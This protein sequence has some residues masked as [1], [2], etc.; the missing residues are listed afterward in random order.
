MYYGFDWQ[1][2]H[3]PDHNKMPTRPPR[4]SPR[5]ANPPTKEPHS[6]RSS[7]FQPACSLL[8]AVASVQAD[9]APDAK[10]PAK[11]PICGLAASRITDL[12]VYRYRVSA[13]RRS[14]SEF[15]DLQDW[16]L[17]F[18]RVDGSSPVVQDGR[19]VQPGCA[20]AWWGLSE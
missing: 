12:C 16:I 19:A 8:L 15:V 3:L 13:R 14:A 1:P 2:A 6:C 17:L 20:M 10:L 9:Q 5:A 7:V 4:T 11:L 18:L